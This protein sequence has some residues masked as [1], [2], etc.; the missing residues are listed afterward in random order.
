MER[1]TLLK[2]FS[3]IKYA[4]S[5]VTGPDTTRLYKSVLIGRVEQLVIIIC[6]YSVAMLRGNT[7]KFKPM[8]I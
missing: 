4:I 3:S 6:C 5:R 2:R 1:T 7:L 8:F